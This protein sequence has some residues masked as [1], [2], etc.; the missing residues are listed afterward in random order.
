MLPHLEQEACSYPAPWSVACRV[1]RCAL[2]DHGDGAARAARNSATSP[3]CVSL[4]SRG[5]TRYARGRA[6]SLACVRSLK[7]PKA[8]LLE[9]TGRAAGRHVL[10]DVFPRLQREAGAPLAIVE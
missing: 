6:R 3:Q 10:L 2:D 9:H 4:D 7:G 5:S 8:Y 1:L